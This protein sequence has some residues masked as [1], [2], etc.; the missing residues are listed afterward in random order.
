[1]KKIDIV[2]VNWNAGE[3]LSDCLKSLVQARLSTNLGKVVVVDN[4]STDTSL[5][6][7]ESIDLPIELIRNKENLGF[8]AACN[9]GARSCRSK[10]LLF[11][12]PDTRVSESSLKVP[13]AFL[14]AEDGANVGACGI[15]LI[16]GDGTVSRSCAR[17]PTAVTF[18]AA[19]VGLSHIRPRWF[20]N[21]HLS[22][23]A[24][25]ETRSVDHII[26]A[27][28]FMRRAI[29]Q[30][31]GGF[32]ER[33][34]VYL[35]D[36]DLSKR[37]IGKGHKVVY[38]ATAQ[39][40]HQGGGTSSQVKSQRLFYSR[41][42]RVQYAFK[43]LSFTGAILVTCCTFFIEPIAMLVRSVMRRAK[44]EAFETL[45]GFA[46]LWAD[47]FKNGLHQTKAQTCQCLG[48]ISFE[49]DESKPRSGAS[50]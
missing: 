50:L 38:L 42:S 32:D 23:W 41:R 26:G 29:F 19:A 37:V 7:L 24:H 3:Q 33:F 40:F 10:Y 14:E 21:I 44:R 16:D 11:L 48:E 13:L 4:A 8:G 22:E 46:M 2:I 31:I 43:H 34:F 25:D 17:F 6:I 47:L 18:C 5:N 20:A 35:E 49:V 28:Y 30:E 36:L 39:A 45:H 15:Q 12:N 1:M 9:Q 27:F